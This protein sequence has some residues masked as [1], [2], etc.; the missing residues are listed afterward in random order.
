M[1]ACLPSRGLRL[2]LVGHSFGTVT[3]D[4]VYEPGG[5]EIDEAGDQLRRVPVV[6]LQEGR[7]VQAEGAG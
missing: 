3:G 7:L 5:L 1:D 6:G 2:E 4:D